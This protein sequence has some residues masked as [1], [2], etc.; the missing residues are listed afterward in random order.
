MK[1]FV[2][3]SLFDPMTE[4]IKCQRHLIEVLLSLGQSETDGVC[5]CEEKLDS[6]EPLLGMSEGRER[7]PAVPP[8]QPNTLLGTSVLQSHY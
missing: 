1:T 7:P 2:V 6:S 8:P 4:I 3:S 5:W